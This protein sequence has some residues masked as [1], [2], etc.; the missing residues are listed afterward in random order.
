VTTSPSAT[1]GKREQRW[2]GFGLATVLALGVLTASC[3]SGSPSDDAIGERRSGGD[4]TT[5]D[6]GAKSFGHAIPTLSVGERRAFAVGNNFFNDNWITAPS[7]TE[8][9][10]GL[11]PVFNAQSCS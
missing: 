10:D 3:S 6:T 9:R 8:G 7:S 5:V 4:A 11:G 2:R 1:C